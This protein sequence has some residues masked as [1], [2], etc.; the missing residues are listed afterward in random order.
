MQLFKAF[1]KIVKQNIVASCIYF[2]VF[3]ALT[4]MLGNSSQE[5]IDSNFQSRSLDLCIVDEDNSEASRIITDYLASIHNIQ[6]TPSDSNQ[7]QD[8][9]YYREVSYI[10]TIPQGFEEKLLAGDTSDLYT[11]IKIP[12]SY[13][14]EFVDQQLM[15][16]TSS[17]QLYVKGGYSLSAAAEHANT[18]LESLEITESIHFESATDGKQ[19]SIF[20]FYQFLPYIFIVAHFKPL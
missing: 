11:C 16:Y 7:L 14:G 17:L 20:Y 2:A 9:L 5:N 18:T 15:Q 19:K 3:M 12:G 10:L 4:F 8:Y 13:T 1:F 6:E